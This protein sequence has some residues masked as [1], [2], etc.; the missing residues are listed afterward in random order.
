[1]MLIPRICVK[2][3]YSECVLS[4][5]ERIRTNNETPSLIT[6]QPLEIKQAFPL[7]QE[8]RPDSNV[9]DQ[10]IVATGTVVRNFT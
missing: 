2:T 7:L 8:K 4:N 9:S 6:N 5:Y 1:M 3:T 10:T